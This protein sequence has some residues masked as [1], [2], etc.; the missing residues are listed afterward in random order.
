MRKLT[1][2]SLAL[3]SSLFI[4][5]LSSPA[6]AEVDTFEVPLKDVH[7]GAVV[8]DFINDEVDECAEDGIDLL[9]GQEAW[10]FVVPGFPVNGTPDLI[11]VE[12][13]FDDGVIV[14]SFVFQK[15]KGWYII[16]QGA[17]TL[18]NAVGIAAPPVQDETFVMN[19]SHT[20]VNTP[21][22]TP[23]PSS[24]P[25]PTP[26]VTP[27]PTATPS[28]TPTQTLPAAVDGNELEAELAQTGF[29]ILPAALIGFG[30]IAAGTII[31]RV[32]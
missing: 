3:T 25:S 1:G 24:T 15:G 11:N 9:P 23:S 17:T 26:T 27:T 19:L 2:L 4:L 13:V 18:N 20:C 31:R 28:S 29:P 16:T 14:D 30:T 5:A 21:T 7:Q 10:H 32:I 8:E 6:L 12:A 22:P